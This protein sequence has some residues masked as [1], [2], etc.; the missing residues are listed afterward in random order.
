MNY[1]TEPPTY[2][3]LVM[4][5]Y[6]FIVNRLR[7]ILFPTLICSCYQNEQNKEIVEQ[8]VSCAL[9]NN[10]LEVGNKRGYHSYN[11][12]FYLH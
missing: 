12:P 2:K 9:L 5:K 4:L 1:S 7:N 8:E 3:L 10:Y 6:S 11:N